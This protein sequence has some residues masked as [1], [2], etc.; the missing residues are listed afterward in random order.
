MVSNTITHDVH[1]EP[2]PQNPSR[3]VT[4]WPW[5]PPPLPPPRACRVHSHGCCIGMGSHRHGCRIG[6]GA[7]SAYNPIL[8]GFCHEAVFIIW[9]F[10]YFV[11][12]VWNA[13]SRPIILVLGD[14]SP[15]MGSAINVTHKKHVFAW[16]DVISVWRTN[17]QVGLPMWPAPV[18]K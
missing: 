7:V 14:F 11:G 9:K 3:Y 1:P 4:P 8:R 13:Y 15:Y 12:L 2:W 16:K 10:N 5:G 17:R 18:K 6:M